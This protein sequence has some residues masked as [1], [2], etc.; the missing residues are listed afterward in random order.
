MAH[1][2]SSSCTRGGEGG[3]V[4]VWHSGFLAYLGLYLRLSAPIHEERYPYLPRPLVFCP[5]FGL[6]LLYC[7]FPKALLRRN[8]YMFVGLR[9]STGNPSCR[10][11]ELS[12]QEII[13]SCIL[14]AAFNYTIHA[15]APLYCDNHLSPSELFINLELSSLYG[16]NSYLYNIC[17]GKYLR[18]IHQMYINI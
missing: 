8:G 13:I 18:D 10:G 11:S 16:R 6:T 14:V 9:T 17:Y 7:W 15:W 3:S 12:V 2:F 1:R 4:H 5:K